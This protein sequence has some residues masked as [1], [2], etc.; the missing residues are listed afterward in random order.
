M[1]LGIFLHRGGSLE[2]WR[3]VGQDKRVVDYYLNRYAKKFDKVYFF[4]YAD[5][6]EKRKDLAENV[7]IVPN[8]HR[9][10]FSI[11]GPMIPFLHKNLINDCDVFRVFHISGTPSS[12]ITRLFF[13]KPYVVTYGY[14]WPKDIWFNKKYL[15]YFMSLPIELFG[16]KLAKKVFVTISD[17]FD[18]VKKYINNEKIVKIPNGVDIDIFK[19]KKIK[20]GKEKRVVYVGRL[21]EAKNLSNLIK[22]VALVD[23]NIEL[24]FVCNEDPMRER[25]RE[26]AKRVGINLI[27]K[28]IIPNEEVVDEVNKADIFAFVPFFAG[29]PKALTEGMACGV[30]CLATDVRGVKE[31]MNDKIAVIC[32]T[33]AEDIG[34]KI[35]WILEH[36][37]ES[38]Q[39]SKNAVKFVHEHYSIEKLM[40]KEI[41]VLKS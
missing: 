32:N 5:I 14:V 13:K 1:N 18:H 33:A 28:G 40:E 2:N 35:R 15:E 25:F 7:I 31:V 30:P 38:E 4:S 10:P 23:K 12:I 22:A 27:I 37:K 19:P 3:T 34:D 20:R 26:E 21:E 8:K 29:H 36:P 9:I 16:L 17:T 6:N 39:I 24:V 41:K 11:Y